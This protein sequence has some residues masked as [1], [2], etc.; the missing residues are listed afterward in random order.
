VAAPLPFLFR[1]VTL[2]QQDNLRLN[3]G[4]AE[5]PVDVLLGHGEVRERHWH[6]Q[7]YNSP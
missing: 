3:G 6:S 1:R 5:L 7:P 2:S 4:I